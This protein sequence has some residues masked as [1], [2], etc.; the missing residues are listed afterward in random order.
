M[1]C[2]NQSGSSNG[3]SNSSGSSGEGGSSDNVAPE[4]TEITAVKIQ[5]TTPPSYSFSSSEE[6]GLNMVVVVR[7]IRKKLMRIKTP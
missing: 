7:A 4:L 6:E 5:P 1:S 3:S 2:A